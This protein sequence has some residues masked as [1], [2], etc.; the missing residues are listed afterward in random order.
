MIDHAHTLPATAAASA[1]TKP[2]VDESY[3]YS[4][5]SLISHLEE[6]CADVKAGR[7]VQVNPDLAP[8]LLK[9]IKGV[10]VTQS[11]S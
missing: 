3:L 10:T 7:L 1:T 11:S 8:P 6:I 4:L 2:G 9:G 5:K